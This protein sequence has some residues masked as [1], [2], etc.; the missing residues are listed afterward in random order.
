MAQEYSWPDGRP[1]E[2]AV[3]KL[4]PKTL[5]KFTG[6]YLFSGL[7]KFK[8]TEKFGKLYVQYPVFGDDPIELFP[9]SETRF[10]TTEQPFVIEFLKET[11]GSIRKAK[12]WNGPED[13]QGEKISDTP[14]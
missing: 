6:V 7:F 2:H 1:Q 10:F 13:V 14:S 8:V 11:D 5:H 3:I 9:E 12:A 4:D